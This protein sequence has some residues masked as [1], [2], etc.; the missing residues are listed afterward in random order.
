MIS[1]IGIAGRRYGELLDR[2]RRGARKDACRKHL[3]EPILLA[4]TAVSEDRP[5][6]AIV[7][8]WHPFRLAEA[9]AKAKRVTAAIAEILRPNGSSC[10]SIRRFSRGV[11]VEGSPTLIP[12]L[13]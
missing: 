13:A 4:G 6:V 2:L 5:V 10:A 11:D 9:A 3:W 1:P 12:P 8:P 7:T